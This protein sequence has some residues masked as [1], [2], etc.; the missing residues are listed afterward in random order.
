MEN[1][2]T[3]TNAVIKQLNSDWEEKQKQKVINKAK[4][5]ISYAELLSWIKNEDQQLRKMAKTSRRIKCFIADGAYQLHRAIEHV[6]GT[7]TSK[8]ER[9]PSGEGDIQTMDVQ[10]AN[11]TRLKVPFGKISL[12]ALSDGEECYITIDYDFTNHELVVF[13][14]AQVR[15]QP[16]FDAIIAETHHNLAEDSIYKNQA[17]ELSDINEPKIMDLSGY[18]DKFMILSEKTEAQLRPLEARITQ[19]TRCIE[20]G[21]PLKY[22]ALMEGGYGTGKT[23]L[24]FKLAYKAINNGWVFIY[25]KDPTKL[26]DA[27]TMAHTIDRSGHGCIIFTEDIDQVTRGNRD[28]AMQRILN[29]LDGGDTKDM[30]VITIFT[31]NHIELIEPTFLRGKR[32]G[33]VINMRPL[34]AKTAKAFLLESFKDYNITEDLTDV[35]DYIAENNIVPAFMAEIVEKV[36]A[37]MVIDDS[38]DVTTLAIRASVE[39]YL[40]QVRLA[41]T[42]DMTQTEA[43]KLYNAVTQIISSAMESV[44]ENVRNVAQVVKDNWDEDYVVK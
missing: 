39:S 14:R 11:G 33:T 44:T 7:V 21:I 23:L 36:K 16:L 13:F 12:D 17:L 1:S 10:L 27:I 42:K 31:T 18:A 43:D 29:T 25:L 2:V 38:H 3:N 35:C 37:S 8:G 40:S 34:D 5:P 22:G 4:S 26:A 20:R 9:Q 41:Q 32:I 24:A 19:P 30:N 15:Y 6:F 28:A